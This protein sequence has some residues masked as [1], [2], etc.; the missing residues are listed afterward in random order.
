MTT[1]DT[2]E[3]LQAVLASSL[4]PAAKAVISATRDRLADFNDQPLA[5][6]CTILILEP[7]DRLDPTSAEYIAYS[8]GWFELV[9]ILSDDGQGQVVLVED[10]PDGDQALLDHCRSHQAN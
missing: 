6:L 3:G 10:R 1:I 9:F 8:D 5:E 7:D 4:H 2:W